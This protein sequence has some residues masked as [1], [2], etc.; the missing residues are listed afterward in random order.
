MCISESEL[1]V[2]DV[3]FLDELIDEE[4]R[5]DII[6]TYENDGG[7]GIYIGSRILFVTNSPACAAFVG[8]IVSGFE[9]VVETILP[10]V[11]ADIQVMYGGYQF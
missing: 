3:L 9:V 11:N 6:G 4:F 1:K 8:K 2:G 10:P 5:V 7:D